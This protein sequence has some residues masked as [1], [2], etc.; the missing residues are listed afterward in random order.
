MQVYLTG[1]EPISLFLTTQTLLMEGVNSNLRTFPDVGAALAYL[2]PRLA[3]EVPASIFLD[4]NMPKLMG[5][6]FLRPNMPV[7]SC[8][9]TT[10]YLLLQGKYQLIN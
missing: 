9:S 10:S 4:L 8:G 5:W 7:Q 3:T 1:D 6:G 2:L